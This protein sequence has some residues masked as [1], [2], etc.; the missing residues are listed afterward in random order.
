MGKTWHGATICNQ[1]QAPK[2]NYEREA[3][4]LVV[5]NYCHHWAATEPLQIRGIPLFS[6]IY[7]SLLVDQ[8]EGPLVA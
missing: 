3:I 6:A 5:L 2:P 1:P 8:Q 4:K 7:Q